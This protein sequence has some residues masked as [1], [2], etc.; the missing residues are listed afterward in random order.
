MTKLILLKSLAVVGL[1]RVPFSDIAVGAAGVGLAGGAATFA[2][3]MMANTG[4]LPGVNG[5]E[6][7]SIFAQPVSKPYA[8]GRPAEF[9]SREEGAPGL[10]F[11]PIGSVRMRPLGTVSP[12]PIEAAAATQEGPKTPSL[13]G[14]RMRGIF[15][16]EALVQ[17]PG[18]FQMV[19]AGSEIEGAGRVTAI[20]ARGRRWVVVTTT[21]I[22]DGD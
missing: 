5:A 7:F 16:S 14:Y 9:A 21:G 8:A 17:G 12:R 13:P 19:R 22:I 10:D 11:T 20:E 6:H 4:Q 18:G 15:Q 3:V 2:V 1:S